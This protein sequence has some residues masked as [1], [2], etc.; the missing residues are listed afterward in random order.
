[1]TLDL[2]L[3][4]HSPE[5]DARLNAYIDMLMAWKKAI[6]L[7]GAS[8]RQDM[9]SDLVPDC[10]Y[11][12]SFMGTLYPSDWQGLCWDF[13]AGAGL[14]GIP[15][16]IFW[17]NGEYIMIEAREKRALFLANV[18][19]SLKLP[20]TGAFRGTVE[21]Y[22]HLPGSPS[23]TSCIISRA[24]MPW[25]KLLPF[26]KNLLENHGHVIVMANQEAPIAPDGWKIASVAA[27]PYKN[28]RRY[29]WAFSP[30]P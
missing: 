17:Q 15:L 28:K 4:T 7:V 18:L 10:L 8:S 30:Q 22:S 6:N 9:L 3:P 27:Y 1:M 25:Q 12:A 11:L 2:R 19:A 20:R 26:C 21:T 16:R 13:G 14:P 5:L 23:R 24:F 29:I